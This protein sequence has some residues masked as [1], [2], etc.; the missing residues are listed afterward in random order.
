VV[1]LA[2]TVAVPNPQLLEPYRALI[3]DEVNV[4]E[5]RIT[6]DV[7]AIARRVLAVNASVV[8]PRLGPA[9]Q[10]GFAAARRGEW[11]LTEAG[12]E[13]AGQQLGADDFTLAIRPRDE[14]STRV[15]DSATGV[16][17][18][19]LTV[20]AELEREGLARDVVRLVQ[21]AR[22][23]AGLDLADRIRLAVDLPAA[24]AAAV[25]AHQDY[26]RTE[27]LAAELKIGTVPPGMSVHETAL[28]G[29]IARVG[30]ARV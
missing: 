25:E 28:D 17:S 27:T 16:V 1:T 11:R 21:S 15:L 5:I 22:R 20:T 2:V 24:Y 23:D 3:A 6:S 10:A 7:D 19:D 12:L 29:G 18:V 30:V 9:A 8:G 13:I 14:A 26:L 4:K